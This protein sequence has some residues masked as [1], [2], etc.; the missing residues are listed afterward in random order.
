MLEVTGQH[1]ECQEQLRKRARD[2]L[3]SGEIAAFIGYGNGSLPWVP[4]PIVVRSPEEADRLVWNSFLTLNLANYL[5]GVLKELEPPRRRGEQVDPSTLPRVGIVATGCWSRNIVI[6]VQ[7]NQVDR[8]RVHIIGISSRGMI[9]RHSFKQ[10]LGGKEALKIVENDHEIEVTL[11]HGETMVLSRWEY[12]RPNCKTCIHPGPVVSDETIGPPPGRRLV[13]ERFRE[14]EEV[15][16]KDSQ[17]RWEWFEEA[18]KDCIRCYACRN[19]CPLCYCPTCFVD[20]S[21][22][23]WVGKSIETPD[24]LTFHILRAYHCAG[25]CTDC[26]ACE[27]VCPVGIPM[28]L[29]TK[30]LIKE[31]Q[32]LFDWEPGMSLEEAPLLGSFSPDDPDIAILKGGEKGT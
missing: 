6:Q 9:S 19:A 29:L 32:M 2:L 3:A 30:K 24:A 11:S 14:I 1:R 15:E 4:R 5:P 23:Q 27:S 26:G 31:A 20:D 10:A 18:F 28:R 22:P 25:R 12:V 7:E 13:D 8:S 21:R 17:G 16:A